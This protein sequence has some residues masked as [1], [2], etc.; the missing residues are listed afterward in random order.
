MANETRRKTAREAALV[1]A[2][3]DLLEAVERLV[4]ASEED[5]D[6]AA[7]FPEDLLKQC[8]AALKKAGVLP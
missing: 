5:G 3:M 2:L 4:S 7:T 6:V 8:R 1:D